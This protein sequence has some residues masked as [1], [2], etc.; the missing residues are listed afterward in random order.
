MVL[1][2]FISRLVALIIMVLALLSMNVVTA[3]AALDCDFGE[4]VPKTRPNAEEGPTAIRAAIFIFD[5]IDIDTK[6]QQFELDLFL[7]AEWKDER[8]GEMVRKKGLRVCQTPGGSIWDPDMFIVNSRNLSILM[9][10]VLYVHANGTV[11]AES[12]IIGIFGAHFDL[13]DFPLDSQTLPLRFISTKYGPDDLY[14]IFEGTGSEEVFSEAGWEASLGRMEP[15]VYEMDLI[16]HSDGKEAKKMASF[17]YEIKAK[18]RIMYY[19]W[20]V[21]VPLCVIVF[22]SWAIFWIDPT[23][24]GVQTGIG[25][26]MLL[27]IVAFLFSLERLLPKID[28]LSR[29][30]IFVYSSLVFVFFAFLQG[31][32]TCSIAAYGKEHLARRI[33]WWSRIAFPLGYTAMFLMIWFV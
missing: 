7:E 16:E 23:H 10:R 17:I 11:E 24:I 33:D 8:L 29:M 31:L 20:K 9:P 13:S 28:Y 26:A 22:A 30:D 2:S 12:R 15:G 19:V 1:P 32:I 21:I 25:T 4:D 27:T 5:L 18:R 6:K 14:I 3:Q